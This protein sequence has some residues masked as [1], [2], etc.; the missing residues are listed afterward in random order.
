[1]GQARPLAKGALGE[2]MEFGFLALAVLGL[3]LGGV[4]KGAIGAGAPVVAVPI[5]AL[6]YSVPVAVVIFTVPNLLSNAWQLWSYRADLLAPKFVWSYAGGGALGAIAG[7][8]LL[9]VISGEALLAGL[10][11]IV[12]IYIALRLMAPH[13]VLSRSLADRV[14]LPVG[15]VAGVMQGAGGISAPISITFLNAMR[16]DRG[17]FIATISAFFG[18]MAVV[19]IPTLWALGL[20]TPALAGWSLLAAVPLFGA[21]PIGAWLGRRID[22]A[23]F[24]KLIL[25]LLAVVALKLFYDAL[26]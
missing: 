18:A 15:I 2:P 8:V 5:L 21:M 22:K 9:A 10:G 19:Q 25:A 20:M 6:I 24:D 14:V 1:M 26:T 4:L 7:S 23:F 17:T 3:A 16:L 13:W 11:C 12:F